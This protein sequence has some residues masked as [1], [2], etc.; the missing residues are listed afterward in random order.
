MKLH[1][2]AAGLIACVLTSD[3]ALASYV[4]GTYAPDIPVWERGF[5]SCRTGPGVANYAEIER[6]PEGEYFTV[7]G[8]QWSWFFVTTKTGRQCH[9]YS[10]FVCD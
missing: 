6:L 8:R 7:V 10:R 1:V 5:L 9:V 3:P 4:C 2:A